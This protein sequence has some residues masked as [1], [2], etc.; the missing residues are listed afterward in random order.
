MKT[1][2][3]RDYK[4]AIGFFNSR[5]ANWNS[6]LSFPCPTCKVSLKTTFQ[7]PNEIDEC[8]KCGA[9]FLISSEKLAA[10]ITKVLEDEQVQQKKDSLEAQNRN[11]LSEQQEKDILQ[12]ISPVQ[13]QQGALK[14]ATDRILSPFYLVAGIVIMVPFLVIMIGQSLMGQSQTKLTPN[15]SLL[16]FLVGL[17]AIVSFGSFFGSLFNPTT[18]QRHDYSLPTTYRELNDRQEA[19]RQYAERLLE[20][21]GEANA[22]KLSYTVQEIAE[23][24]RQIRNGTYKRP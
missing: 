6:K 21:N 10:L 3:V 2:I 15:Q 4:V 11:A 17:F 23:R 20:S 12:P 9:C 14:R 18:P 13:S 5:N 22:K 24:D 19:E 1:L 16:A 7:G 8:P